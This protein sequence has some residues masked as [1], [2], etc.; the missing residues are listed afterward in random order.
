MKYRFIGSVNVENA[1]QEVLDAFQD[2]GYAADVRE[3]EIGTCFLGRLLCKTETPGKK[4]IVFVL[5][6]ISWL[7]DHV[8]E[9]LINQEI[10]IM[11][12]IQLPIEDI[13]NDMPASDIARILELDV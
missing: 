11:H 2:M 1:N 8:K 13:V 9:E 12:L 6:D 10:E 3:L 4:F 5:Y 7:Q